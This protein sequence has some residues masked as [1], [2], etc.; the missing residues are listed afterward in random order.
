MPRIAVFLLLVCL[1]GAAATQENTFTPHHVSKLR[2]VMSAVVSPDGK[3]IAYVLAVPRNIP[4]EANGTAWT[5]LHV[6]DTNGVNTPYLTG[7]VNVDAVAWTPDG[8]G[9]SYLA[10]RDK[11]EHR[12][13]YIM[14]LRGGESRKVL[15]HSTDIQSYSWAPDGK[16]VAF[17]ATVPLSK[18]KK[19]RAD[20]GFNQ[21][22]YE[23]ELDPVRIWI[24]DVG[25]DKATMLKRGGSASELHW[26]PKNATLAVA[27][28]PTPLVD[29]GL[30]FRKVT[31]LSV[32][33]KTAV[34]LGNSGK[35][36]QLA[37]SPD[38]KRLAFIDSED[39]NDPLQGRLWVHNVAGDG[40][41]VL[42]KFM[43]HVESIAWKD[44]DTVLYQAAEGV[45]TS[46]G[47]IHLKAGTI[48]DGAKRDVIVP[49]GGPILNHL[50][51]SR[52]GKTL[53][54]VGQSEGHPPEVYVLDSV[55]KTPRR[56]TDSNPWLRMMR[57]AKQEVVK[58][59]ARDGLE[60]EGLL[61]R[62][63]E[64]KE[65]K[66]YPLVVTVH[67]GPESHIPNGW[68]TVYHS[69][70]Q[71]GAAQG[72]AVFYPN[73]RG[74]TGRGVA[75]SKL[76]QAKAAKAEF[77]DIVDGV[78]HLIKTGLVD[79]KKVGVT[80]GSYGG[81]ATAWC[82]TYYSD[83]FAAGVMFVGISNNISKVGT[84]DIPHEMHLVHH[85]KWLWEDWDY[86]V[87]ASPIYYTDKAKTP[88]LIMHGKAD[89][90]VH[91]SQSLEL[92]RNLKLR[93]KAPVRLVYYPGEGHG[94]RKT[95]AKLDYNLRLLQWMKHYLQGP[96]GAA[97]P[98]D[99]DYGFTPKSKTSTTSWEGPPRRVLGAIEA[100]ADET[101]A[102]P[103]T[104]RGCPCCLRWF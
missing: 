88:L 32:D 28:A 27:L 63:L 18:E 92:Y 26:N 19:K 39:K 98:I 85:R 62:P 29:D 55:S 66:R 64:E 31:L 82:S 11:E 9:I 41:D 51:A 95:A 17:L 91:P 1:P 33:G 43:G 16:R 47:A 15:S 89:P 45:F 30:M 6:V 49:T 94:N 104:G 24:A 68:L 58:Y 14:P 76:G 93:G 25:A 90:R 75:F 22:I 67:G 56:L 20:E 12:S 71:V 102:A 10:K 77:D 3:Q 83:R 40:A 65:G 8:S 69:L 87:K 5:E 100:G 61:I 52:D 4:K 48:P 2:A 78:D 97:P 59:K 74:S 101:V 46:V 53:A 103:W 38:G 50:T 57:F 80:G 70:G 13:L 35:V 34:N 84:T 79:E 60:I 21:E 96:G 81:Y 54:F 37:W 36:G 42:P 99:L 73:Y 7:P 23:E 72:M 44:N 86:F